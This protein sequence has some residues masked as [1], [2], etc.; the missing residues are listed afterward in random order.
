MT[1]GRHYSAFGSLRLSDHFNRPGIIEK[2][3]NLDDL[4]RGL[5][6]QPQSN[7]DEYFDKEVLIRDRIGDKKKKQELKMQTHKNACLIET[8]KTRNIIP[9]SKMRFFDNNK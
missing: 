6:Y 3:N 7:T 1:E 4:T 8:I 5:A 2:G 9:T